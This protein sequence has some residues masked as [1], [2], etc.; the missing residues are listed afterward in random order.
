MRAIGGYLGMEV[1]EGGPYHAGAIPLNLGRHALEM[2]IKARGYRRMH[3]PRFTCDVLKEPLERCG[4][5]VAFHALD[6]RMDPLVDP[7]GLDRDEG[8]LVTNYFGLKDRMIAG[9]AQRCSN[10]I[11]DN[12]QSFYSMP[13]PGVDTFYSC[14]KFFGVADGGYLYTDAPIAR[15]LQRDESFGR[16]EHLLRSWDR[17]AED[18]YPFF[19]ENEARMVGLPLR[20]MSR[21]TERVMSGIDHSGIAARRR[22]NRD[23]LHA[24]LG[25]RNLLSIDPAA[26]DVPM[27]YPLLD[28]DATLRDR[29]F[30]GKVYTPRYWPGLLGP[31]EPGT[32]E[33]R[34]VNDIVHLPVDQRYGAADMDRILDLITA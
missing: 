24:Q 14:R 1:G 34:F 12:A 23:R 3:V 11:V 10:L 6:D 20:G 17:G 27:V 18:G 26:A 13:L 22:G 2:V 19:Q 32:P 30:A 21:L 28:A 8:L 9:L 16:Y 25:S 15:E 29:L 5:E 31:V 4:V 7:S 33:H